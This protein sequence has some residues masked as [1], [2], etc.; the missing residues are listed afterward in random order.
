MI[1]IT[2]EAAGGVDIRTFRDSQDDQW[3]LIRASYFVY[4][5]S[6]AHRHEPG[7]F[8]EASHGID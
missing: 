2:D 6:V 7:D 1:E 5:L 3:V 8:R 4:L